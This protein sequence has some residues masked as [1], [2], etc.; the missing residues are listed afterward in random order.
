MLD[1]GSMYV[2]MDAVRVPIT[3]VLEEV[4]QQLEEG[5]GGLG[6]RGRGEGIGDF[7]RGR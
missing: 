3:A 2:S 4:M 7:Q 6:S 1:I 5:V